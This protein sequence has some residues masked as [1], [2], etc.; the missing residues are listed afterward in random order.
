MYRLIYKSRPVSPL[1]WPQ[2]LRIL[3]TSEE[4]NEIQGITGVLLTSENSFLQ[5]LEGRY[6]AVNQLFIKIVHDP[7]HKDVQLI[8]FDLIDGRLFAG[9]GMKGLGLF[10][11]NQSQVSLLKAKY[12]E[13]QGEVRFPLESWQALSLI[14]D[15]EMIHAL[16]T[17]KQA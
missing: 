13:D 14:N 4:N 2:I 5:V 15:L 11:F 12:G 16:P 8:S 10:N 7:R 6:E 17:W 1:D 9:W 3:H